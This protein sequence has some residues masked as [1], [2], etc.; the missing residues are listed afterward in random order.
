[1]SARK[2]GPRRPPIPNVV[3]LLENFK[4][5]HGDWPQIGS[6]DTTLLVRCIR[7]FEREWPRAA[8]RGDA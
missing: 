6:E 2:P 4:A 1:M 3:R 7:R 8:R 5:A